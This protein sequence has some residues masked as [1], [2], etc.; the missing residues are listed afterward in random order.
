M[1]KVLLPHT[2]FV[3]KSDP[4]YIVCS[5]QSCQ[6]AQQSP[7]G[8]RHDVVARAMCLI[9]LSTSGCQLS[10]EYEPGSVIC[11]EITICRFWTSDHMALKLYF[12]INP[13]TKQKL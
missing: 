4:S 11:H 1:L 9:K 3:C 2:T 7:V 10:A 13:D 8:T 12:A 6:H 5:S